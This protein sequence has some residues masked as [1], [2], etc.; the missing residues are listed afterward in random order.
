MSPATSVFIAFLVTQSVS[1]LFDQQSPI[2]LPYPL[3]EPIV[4]VYNDTLHVVGGVTNGNVSNHQSFTIPISAITTNTTD[5][6]SIYNPALPSFWNDSI[7]YSTQNIVTLDEKLYIML[8]DGGSSVP[9]LLI[10]NLMN[11]SFVT[12]YTHN[13]QN[14]WNGYN[15]TH[16]WNDGCMVSNADYI[17]FVLGIS[18]D[19]PDTLYVALLYA[20]ATNEWTNLH[21]TTA[22]NRQGMGCIYDN[23]Y[24]HLFGGRMVSNQVD[25]DYY[26]SC[27]TWDEWRDELRNGIVCDVE[28]G[29]LSYARSYFH[30]SQLQDTHFYMFHGGASSSAR[31]NLELVNIRTK[32]IFP[33]IYIG[34]LIRIMDETLIYGS[35]YAI[36]NDY[37]ISIGGI[38]E[39]DDT[40]MSRITYLAVE[41]I[42]D[43]DDVMYT[44]LSRYDATNDS[45]YIGEHLSAQSSTKRLVFGVHTNDTF[46]M[47]F[48]F[49]SMKFFNLTFERMRSGNERYGRIV[50]HYQAG[51][52]VLSP[53]YTD[54][55]NMRTI[56]L[57]TG[58]N[59][60]DDYAVFWILW[61]AEQDEW[62]RDISI[63][64]FNIGFGDSPNRFGD[65]LTLEGGT[66]SYLAGHFTAGLDA[67][68]LKDA[69]FEFYA[70]QCVVDVMI[71]IDNNVF[72]V[73]D[74]LMIDE[75]NITD[76]TSLNVPISVVSETI[77]SIN[78][79]M[80]IR[81]DDQCTLCDAIGQCFMCSDGILIDDLETYDIEQNVY[82]VQFSSDL[83]NLQ[84]LPS[85]PLVLTRLVMQIEVF[86]DINLL[87]N[88]TE[89]S[90][91]YPNA[92]LYLTPDI[93]NESMPTQPN[94]TIAIDFD[95]DLLV[96]ETA[97]IYF[98]F[99]DDSCQIYYGD[100][101]PFDCEYPLLIPYDMLFKDIS[102]NTYTISIQSD[103]VELSG[104]TSQVFSRE[105][106]SLT[107]NFSKSVYLGEMIRFNVVNHN[108]KY[109]QS[110]SGIRI[111]NADYSI[112]SHIDIAYTNETIFC[113]IT[114]AI[115]QETALC[116]D[117]G[118][119]FQTNKGL[120][121]MGDNIT[122]S[123]ESK[124]TYLSTDTVSI[125]IKHCPIGFGLIG[126]DDTS[127]TCD[128]CQEGTVGM[129]SNSKCISC[130][131]HKGIQ[132]RGI[133]ELVVDYNYWV[134][135]DSVSNIFSSVCP[136]EYCCAMIDGCLYDT[137]D[138]S[139]L[140]Q[141]NRNPGTTFCSS[142]LAGFSEV[143][144]S[145]GCKK[146]DEDT[147]GIL[148][149]PFLTALLFVF[150]VVATD[151]T[152]ANDPTDSQVP[153]TPNTE[154]DYFSLFVKDDVKCL[155][156]AYIRPLTY[157]AQSIRYI[158]IQTGVAYYFNP[159]MKFLSL[160]FVFLSSDSS[161][162]CFM[163]NLDALSKQLWQ[164]CLVAFMFV[165]IF[166]WW[167][168][169]RFVQRMTSKQSKCKGCSNI[170]S[171]GWGVVWNIILISMSTMLTK[172]FVFL[173]CRTN[174]DGSS[175]HFF[176]GDRQCFGTPW[177]I[178]LLCLLL[179]VVFWVFLFHLMRTMDP[180]K[181]DSN[182]SYLSSVTGPYKPEYYYWEIVMTARRF[183]IAFLVSFQYLMDEEPV[184]ECIL[185]GVLMIFLTVHVRYFP[186]KY[187]RVN[188]L[189]TVCCVIFI[190]VLSC[191]V[192]LS[193]D[194][195]AFVFTIGV[196]IPVLWFVCYVIVF[197][198]HTVGFQKDDSNEWFKQKTLNKIAKI[199]SRYP[200]VTQV[201]VDNPKNT[202]KRLNPTQTPHETKMDEE[203][204]MATTKHKQNNDDD[205]E[206]SSAESTD[207]DKAQQR[208]N[209]KMKAKYGEEADH[210]N[211]DQI[212]L[213]VP[214]PNRDS[215]ES[216][217]SQLH[218]DAVEGESD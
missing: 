129:R 43:E 28:I 25:L 168:L 170:C 181:R 17:W 155:K 65:F 192:I 63:P 99:Y 18:N 42:F 20:I 5:S 10:Y 163:S 182:R 54:T 116:E 184:T 104:P 141:R 180:T 19:P 110:S 185:I 189:D 214:L 75:Y 9:V 157:F 33:S 164:L 171:F 206:D 64:M 23:G 204:E 14:L 86:M 37:L 133:S 76:A 186:F 112:S 50:F 12:N 26:E 32:Q 152:Y 74:V 217:S 176:F 57:L 103:D 169:S 51:P 72:M 194:L 160:D 175:V 6:F 140:C 79:T 195:S 144:G 11:E 38:K 70:Y 77:L 159:V 130:D 207:E 58:I 142:C 96:R 101:E 92:E 71:T 108:D 3:F 15:K 111:T 30:I 44:C 151:S 55:F 132:C 193:T 118:I 97:Q 59:M 212:D 40:I 102:D 122:L 48:D 199:Q 85:N 190:I 82:D 113:E 210:D 208:V 107:L 94:G 22:A 196:I 95:R 150:V 198:V 120:D 127:W 2:D 4:A 179:V 80:Y 60:V 166:I 35:G 121:S 13:I 154:T 161:G 100:H 41:D 52:E 81:E 128:E 119:G 47:H 29:T 109:V 213:A 216:S 34:D 183:S 123:I 125:Q 139:S 93:S 202:V 203:I 78:H 211:A 147:F 56:S 138:A 69:I 215:D 131:D 143:F 106:Q 126:S 153:L 209:W 87:G 117:G 137:Q 8:H 53:E 68:L 105:I 98:D 146:C 145:T 165:S 45:V 124:D 188:V 178:A 197:I 201:F 148:L 36:T 67:I 49:G 61:K 7:L 177:F 135:I 84:I 90:V 46:T 191:K 66:R 62:G 167:L 156:I 218:L 172:I 27:G 88:S 89:A 173:S 16:H 91:L 115:S 1:L 21:F 73:G 158:T 149:Y 136:S 31:Q 114:A 39:K 162:I 134:R 24:I 205:D 83:T 187:M 200:E 174:Y